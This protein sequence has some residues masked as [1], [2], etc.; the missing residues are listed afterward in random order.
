[1]GDDAESADDIVSTQDLRIR[2][3][4]FGAVVLSSIIDLVYLICLFGILAA[5]KW[6]FDLF[7]QS[8]PAQVAIVEIGEWIGLGAMGCTCLF[9]IVMDVVRTIRRTWHVMMASGE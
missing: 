2:A 3:K 1:M 9:F 6:L 8:F 7:K 5:G 4:F